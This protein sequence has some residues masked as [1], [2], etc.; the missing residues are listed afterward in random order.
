[1]QTAQDSGPRSTVM[2]ESPT[3]PPAAALTFAELGAAVR[4]IVAPLQESLDREVAQRQALQVEASGLRD[5]LAAAQLAKA[6]ASGETNTERA[7]REAAEA[8]QRTYRAVSTRCRTSSTSCRPRPASHRV[9]A[10]GG[11]SEPCPGPLPA[12]CSGRYGKC[13]S[14]SPVRRRGAPTA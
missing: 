6:M 12:T 14:G 8:R 10:D 3:S 7:R 9:G 4:R 5:Q 2:A 13:S 1:M 11:T